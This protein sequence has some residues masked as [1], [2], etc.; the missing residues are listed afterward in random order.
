MRN[1]GTKKRKK[2]REKG[3]EKK[4]KEKIK[5]LNKWNSIPKKNTSQFSPSNKDKG[6]IG[7]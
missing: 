4:E 7:I 3:K 5:D 1:W 2:N 6:K